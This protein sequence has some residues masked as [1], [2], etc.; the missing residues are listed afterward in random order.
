MFEGIKYRSL[1]SELV[2]DV[3]VTIYHK[4]GTQETQIA[5]LEKRSERL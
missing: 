3:L 5:T 4:D 2:E 1:D